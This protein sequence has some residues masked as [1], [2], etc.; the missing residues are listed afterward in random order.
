VRG[1]TFRL[2]APPLVALPDETLK[3]LF[4]LWDPAGD[5]RLGV[6]DVVQL[7]SALQ[8]V[9]AELPEEAKQAQPLLQQHEHFQREIDPKQIKSKIQVQRQNQSD[10]NQELKRRCL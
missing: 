4:A 1:A 10:M 8:E 2:G 9:L 3:A 7:V 6:D 5:G